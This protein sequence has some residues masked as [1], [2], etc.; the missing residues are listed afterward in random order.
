M[1]KSKDI[2]FIGKKH[3]MVGIGCDKT[4]PKCGYKSSSHLNVNFGDNKI[5]GDYCMRCWGRWISRN[6][7]K[8]GFWEEELEK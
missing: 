7:P 6:I 2:L 8:M 4:C 1:T 5:D 3:K